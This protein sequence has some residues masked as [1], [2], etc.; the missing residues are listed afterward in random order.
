MKLRLGFALGLVAMLATSTAHAGMRKSTHGA[1]NRAPLAFYIC[2]DPWV[3]GVVGR[4]R[5]ELVANWKQHARWADRK[6]QCRAEDAVAVYGPY[7]YRRGR[8]QVGWW[9]RREYPYEGKNG[10]SYSAD[11]YPPTP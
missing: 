9:S 11:G 10:A 4:T 3:M 7:R 8:A 5:Q 1:L 2:R 6:R